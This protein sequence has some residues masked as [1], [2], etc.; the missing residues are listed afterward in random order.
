MEAIFLIWLVLAIAV[1]AYAGSKG[2]N[3][4]MGFLAAAVLSPLIGF[5]IVAGLA[6]KKA[7]KELAA[8]SRR[9]PPPPPL[10]ATKTCPRCAETIKAAAVVCRYC[11]ADLTKSSTAS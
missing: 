1:G 8:T 5:I 11:S 10:E 3:G 4:F 6:D 7:A 9:T 2:R